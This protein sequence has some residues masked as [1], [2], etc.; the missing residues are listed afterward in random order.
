MHIDKVKHLIEAIDR[1]RNDPD[2]PDFLEYDV[3]LEQCS[4]GDKGYKRDP[5]K[6]G[7]DIITCPEFPD[8]PVELYDEYFKAL[9]LG[10]GVWKEK[11]AIFINVNY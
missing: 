5:K 4:E 1:F 2:H 6:Q 8:D 7:W 9:G 10:I 11:K 3:Y